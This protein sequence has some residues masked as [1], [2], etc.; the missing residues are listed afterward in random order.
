MRL[1]T[2]LTAAFALVLTAEGLHA[3]RSRAKPK[4]PVLPS[5]ANFFPPPAPLLGGSDACASAD[6]IA[7]VGLFGFDDTTATTGAEGQ[8]EALCNEFGNTAILADV[9]FAWTASASGV[10]RV[11]TV[12]Q[13][14]VDT[15]LAAY[16]GSAC[17]TPQ[18]AIACNDDDVGS[19]TFQSTITFACAAGSTYLLQVGLFPGPFPPA[20]PGIGNLAI[21]IQTPSVNDTCTAPTIVSGFG[22]AAPHAFDATLATTGAQGQNNAACESFA[23]RA[24]DH[25]VWFQW[26]APVLGWVQLTTCA[27]SSADTKVAVYQGTGCPVGAPLVCDDDGC[28]A[29]GGGSTARFFASVGTT[30]TIQLG[31]FP[32]QPGG[33]GVFT[34]EAFSPAVGD[35]CSAPIRIAGRGPHAFDNRAATT[36]TE[37]Q[38][39]VLCTKVSDPNPRIHYDLWYAWTATGTGTATWSLCGA[40]MDSKIAVYAGSACPSGAALACSDDGCMGI[41]PAELS[42]P[43]TAGAPYVLQLGNWPGAVADLGTFT[44]DVAGSVGTPFCFGSGSGTACPCSPAPIEASVASNGCPNSNYAGGAHLRADGLASVTSDTLVLHGSGMPNGPCLYFQGSARQSGGAGS[45]FGDGLLCAGGTLTR[46]PIVFNASGASELPTVSSG[47]ISTLGLVPP[48]GGTRTYQ[49]WYRDANVFCTA[50]TF[51]LTNGVEIAWSP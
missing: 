44:I 24:I 45:T 1:R 5:A 51:N 11:T 40:A 48:I 4:R 34:I 3:Q 12:N 15:K 29:V 37:G 2:L 41:G 50:A 38:S 21:T 25:D 10:A 14:I 6:P 31:A 35:G 32:G 36:G 16:P 33:V 49:V 7:G 9:W 17:P 13:T 28:G 42:F 43:V 8:T 30:Y 18:S 19:G 20:V 47:S 46:L 27:G 23:T 26:T 39:E 22:P